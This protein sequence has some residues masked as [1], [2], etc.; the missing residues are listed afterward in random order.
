MK[1][2]YIAL[3]NCSSTG[4]VQE[5]LKGSH[6]SQPYQQSLPFACSILAYSRKTLRKSSKIFVEHVWH[7]ARI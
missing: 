4:I 1:D 6:L 5:S 2:Q 7:V 3:M